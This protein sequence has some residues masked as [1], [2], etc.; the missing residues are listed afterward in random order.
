MEFN[1]IF[2][3]IT[4]LILIVIVLICI[5]IPF[6][7]IS[8]YQSYEQRYTKAVLKETEVQEL[9][10]SKKNADNKI[11]TSFISA[12]SNLL[13]VRFKQEKINLFNISDIYNIKK[14]IRT[15]SLGNQY[16]KVITEF[17]NIE[18]RLNH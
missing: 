13:G 4:K 18:N 7:N 9:L 2:T 5:F 10:N 1:R 15:D 12:S 8:K 6:Y 3:K 16:E 14:A 17:N 11:E